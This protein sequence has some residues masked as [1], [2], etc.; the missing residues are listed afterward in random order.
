LEDNSAVQAYTYFADGGTVTLHG[1][2]TLIPEP[3][4]LDLVAVVGTKLLVRRRRTL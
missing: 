1:I 2:G 4:S 3:E